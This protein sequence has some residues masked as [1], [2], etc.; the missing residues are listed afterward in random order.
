[1]NLAEVQ[2]LFRRFAAPLATYAAISAKRRE[3]AEIMA[4]TLWTALIAGPE[5]E[6]ATWKILRTN[7]KLD[8][9]SLRAI[10]KMYYE[11]MKPVVKEEQIA[12]LKERYR[13]RENEE[14]GAARPDAPTTERK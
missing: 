7:G 5:M 2:I 9:D 10:K 6:E 12:S 14:P 11:Q 8:D 13:V 3:G 4:R 1:M